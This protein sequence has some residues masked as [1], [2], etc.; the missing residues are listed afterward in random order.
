M[1][2][3]LRAAALAVDRG[4]THV[5]GQS[6]RQPGDPGD[7]VGLLAVLRDAATDDLLDRPGVDAGFLHQ[8][9]LSGTQQLGCVQT[10]QPAAPL[11]DRAAGG[12][13][14]DRITHAVRLE[15]V[16]LL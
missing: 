3:L 6:G 14:D 16:S 7:V 9:P 13:D 2:G 5:F 8:R 1:I 12:F 15:H 4:R 11:A 10:G